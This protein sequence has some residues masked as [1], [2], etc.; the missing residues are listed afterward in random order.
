MLI[1]CLKC[2]GCGAEYPPDSLM[3]LCPEDGRPVE[4]I[5]DLKRLA[6]SQPGAAWYDPGR[7]DLWRFGGL[8]PL[9][10]NDSQ[11]R[12]HIITQGEGHTP[13]LDFSDHPLARKAGFALG[14]KD[15]GKAHHGFGANPTQSFK[16]RGMV[17]TVSMAHWHG[18][19]R[20]AVPTQGNAG[21]SLC[22]YANAAGMSAVVAM[23]DNT[24]M[25]ILG[26]VAALAHASDRFH[27]ELVG[28]SIRDAGEILKRDWIP[29]EDRWHGTCGTAISR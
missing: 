27:L 24:P 23:P 10:I 25:P 26:G 7:A 5:L 14:L 28:G 16:D 22:Y 13:V 8:L 9:D 15:E 4:I 12:T 21:D 29:K 17:M 1:T 3:N 19:E 18:L 11:D 6:S 20:L 2:T